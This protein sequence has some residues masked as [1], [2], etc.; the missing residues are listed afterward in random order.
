[1]GNKVSIQFKN[2][3]DKSVILFSHW[4]GMSLVKIAKT[5]LKDLNKW[6][7]K[8]NSNI[9]DPIQRKEPNTVMIDFIRFLTDFLQLTRIEGDL[10]LS[11]DENDGDNSNNGHHIID[12]NK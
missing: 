11:V 3:E 2:N 10:Y 12:L 7:K 8:R 5:Y 4:M 9:I 1:M 6:L